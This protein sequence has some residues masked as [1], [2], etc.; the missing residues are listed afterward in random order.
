MTRWLMV[1]DVWWLEPQR[2]STS[3]YSVDAEPES[4][5]E[6]ANRI[7]AQI[8]RQAGLKNLSWDGY[9]KNVVKSHDLQKL[10]SNT[11]AHYVH[12]LRHKNVRLSAEDLLSK[13]PMHLT[14]G[15]SHATSLPKIP[16]SMSPTDPSALISPIFPPWLPESTIVDIQNEL[17]VTSCLSTSIDIA[18]SPPG[19]LISEIERDRD[20][21]LLKQMARRV[22]SRRLDVLH[23]WRY[24]TQRLR[25]LSSS[26]LRGRSGNDGDQGTSEVV[27]QRRIENSTWRMTRIKRK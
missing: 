12:Y 11:Q 10:R 16:R 3:A 22:D 7:K 27:M 13:E 26:F 17:I 20:M 14:K 9:M 19:Q 23:A 4:S 1:V 6:F 5:I 24:Y 2:R 18:A 8:S 15:H 21:S 25:H